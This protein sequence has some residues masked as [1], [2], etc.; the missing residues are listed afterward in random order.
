MYERKKREMSLYISILVD[1]AEC[2]CKLLFAI[3][4]SNFGS[5]H[6]L[7][8]LIVDRSTA[9][10]VNISNHLVDLLQYPEETG[11]EC[12][13]KGFQQQKDTILLGLKHNSK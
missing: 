1:N 11:G 13:F 6:V 4:L 7:K 10:F 3:P 2:F 9:I 12:Y 8:L 5:H